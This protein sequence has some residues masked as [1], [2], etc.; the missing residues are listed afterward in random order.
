MRAPLRGQ[1]Q[2]QL[3][4]AQAVLATAATAVDRFRRDPVDPA[5]VYRPHTARSATQAGG[6]NDR[7]A[8]AWQRLHRAQR[9]V[10]VLE[11]KARTGSVEQALTRQ[12]VFGAVVVRTAHGWHTVARVNTRTVSVLTGHSWVDRYPF[13]QLL[14]V[15]H[16]DPTP[17][18]ARC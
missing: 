11:A 6:R 3:T 9:A 14:E 4:E 13:D 12:D 10:D 8:Q 16:P 1:V 7:E 15:R 18:G 5:S 2:R 17:G